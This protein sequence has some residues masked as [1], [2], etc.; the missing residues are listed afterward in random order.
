MIGARSSPCSW[1][2]LMRP[3]TQPVSG[4][5]LCDLTFTEADGLAAVAL[6]CIVAPRTARLCGLDDD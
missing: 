2:L 6:I 1:P 5:A 3:T 4:H